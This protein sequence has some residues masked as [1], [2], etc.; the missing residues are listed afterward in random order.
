MEAG[1]VDALLAALRTASTEPYPSVHMELALAV[2]SLGDIGGGALR[3]EIINAGGVDI[4]KQVAADGDPAVANACN[5]A[6]TAITGNL[7]SRTAGSEFYSVSTMLFILISF[8]ANTKTAMNHN[9]AGG[10]PDHTPTCPVPLG[11]LEEP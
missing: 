6:V 8:T 7:W 10:C 5:I 9:W 3:K 11:D 2:G 4:L 1:V